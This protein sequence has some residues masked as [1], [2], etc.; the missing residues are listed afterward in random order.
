LNTNYFNNHDDVDDFSL[1]DNS[2]Q[3][4]NDRMKTPILTVVSCDSDSNQSNAKV[5]L[6]LIQDWDNSESQ[7]IKRVKARNFNIQQTKTQLYPTLLQRAPTPTP[8]PPLL[9]S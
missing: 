4:N 8:R 6:I 2:D 5:P 7:D 9:F 3:D 1:S